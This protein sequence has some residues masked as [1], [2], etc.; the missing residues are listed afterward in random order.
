M[1]E[2]LAWFLKLARKQTLL[3]VRDIEG[4]QWCLQSLA[5]EHHP[6]WIVGHL[7]LADCYLLHLLG[8]EALPSDFPDLLKAHGPGAV[9]KPASAAYQPH[10]I[11][12]ERLRQSGAMRCDAVSRMT[13]RD[14]SKPNPDTALVTT[15]PTIGHHLQA[16]V[17]HEGHHGGQLSAWRH[18]QGL[19]AVPWVFAPTKLP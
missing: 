1:I 18:R 19:C 12:A 4:E 14:L 2:T 3:M 11:L 15:Q 9:P 6:A 13:S 16:I 17:F 10:R 8:V 7:L 5:G